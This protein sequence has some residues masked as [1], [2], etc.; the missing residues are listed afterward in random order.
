MVDVGISVADF[1]I[2]GVSRKFFGG[3]PSGEYVLHIVMAMLF[4]AMVASVFYGA[5]DWAGLPTQVAYS[6]A[7]V[8]SVLRLVM[9]IMAVLVFWSGV[10]D[11]AAAAKLTKEAPHEH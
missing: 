6:P 3:L 1:M 4:G 10:M 2:E 7:E 11:L 9:E 5:G 8:P